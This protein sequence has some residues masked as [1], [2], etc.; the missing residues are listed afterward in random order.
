[1]LQRQTCFD[2]VK[3]VM[4]SSQPSEGTQTGQ[5]GT[6]LRRPELLFHQGYTTGALS[7]IQPLSCKE[8]L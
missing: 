7:F 8:H 6:Q 5:P 4:S 1:M 3:M 2:L